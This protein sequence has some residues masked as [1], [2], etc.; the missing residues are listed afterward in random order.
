MIS[1]AALALNPAVDFSF[2]VDAL[3]PIHKMRGTDERHDPGGGAINVAR[4]FVRLGG[5]ARCYYLSGGAGGAAL[6]ALLD[7]HQLVRMRVPIEGETRIS[8]TVLERASGQEYRFTTDGPEV[9]RQEGEKVLALLADARCEFIVASGSLPRGLADDFYA[10]VA[11]LASKRGIRLVLDSSGRGLAGGLS[12]NRVFL[13]KPSIG[14]LRALTGLSLETEES[15]AD[16]AREL[17]DKGR[18][19]HVAVTM[20]NLGAMLVNAEGMQRLPAIPVT[21]A[22]AVGAGDS[23]LA[24]MIFALA[25]GKPMAEALRHGI[26]AGAASVLNPGTGLAHPKDIARL[27]GGA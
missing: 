25:A 9:R 23:F 2:S 6:D 7:L 4:V 10:D 11:A 1:I 5:D 19:E 24:A 26:A 18:A 15:I 27:L 20:G 17:V 8:T 22:S 14:E 3:R 16:A 12:G 13:V 21:V